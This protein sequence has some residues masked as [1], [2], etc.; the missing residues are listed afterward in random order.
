MELILSPAPEHRP[1][2]ELGRSYTP[3][4]V[5]Q[6]IVDRL[7]ERWSL[8]AVLEPCVGGGAF[9]R[10]VRSHQRPGQIVAGVDLDPGAPGRELVDDFVVGDFTTLPARGFDLV[11]TNPPFGPDVGQAVTLAIARKARAAG[12]V[13]ALLLPGDYLTQVG[14]AELVA[15]CAEVWPIVGRVWSN[16]RGMVVLVWDVRHRG[17]TLFR[18][19]KVRS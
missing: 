8:R 14:W 6:A 17:P 3:D 9:V 13:C 19:L 2:D 15:D 10:A 16:T 18:P 12:D 7:A 11:V 4:H 5:A 1:G